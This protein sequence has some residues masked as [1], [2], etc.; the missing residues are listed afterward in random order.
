M[1]RAG[2]VVLRTAAIPRQHRAEER[3]GVAR[4][5]TLTPIP[6]DARAGYSPQSN[7]RDSKKPSGGT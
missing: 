7:N 5:A 6:C 2:I 4:Y 1:P 3:R